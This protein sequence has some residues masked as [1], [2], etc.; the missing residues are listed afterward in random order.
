MQPPKFDPT[1]AN[2]QA[3]L[4]SL[5]ADPRDLLR[6][7]DSWR[8]EDLTP[9][10]KLVMAQLRGRGALGPDGVDNLAKILALAPGTPAVDGVAANGWDPN[11]DGPPPTSGGDGPQAPGGGGL[12]GLDDLSDMAG[13][14][15]LLASIAAAGVAASLQM[16]L[17]AP[18]E[19]SAAFFWRPNNPDMSCHQLE[20]NTYLKGKAANGFFG[21]AV[22]GALN[23]LAPPRGGSGPS[24]PPPTSPAKP[25]QQSAEELQALKDRIHQVDLQNGNWG[26]YDSNLNAKVQKLLDDAAN[27]R[28]VDPRDVA[29]L[30]QIQSGELAAAG[31]QLAANA[32]K[33]GGFEMDADAKE[34][35]AW[36][37]QHSPEAKAA[38]QNDLWNQYHNL[39]DRAG[40]GDL[41]TAANIGSLDDW[42]SKVVKTN[43]ADGSEYID[44]AA[45]DQMK[46]A[47]TASKVDEI[48]TDNTFSQAIA[49]S[50]NNAATAAYG[51]EVGTKLTIVALSAF[52]GG[53]AASML[54]EEG[55]AATLASYG[56]SSGQATVA[57]N[58][59]VQGM[60]AAGQ[61]L[62]YN[63]SL[64]ENLY[65]ATHEG[66]KGFTI[67]LITGGVFHA[68]ASGAA[69]TAEAA[70][71][72]AAGTAAAEG[73]GTQATGAASQS[74]LEKAATGVQQ[75]SKTAAGST[76]VG[77]VIGGTIGAASGGIDAARHGKSVLEGAW[78]GGKQGALEGGVGG[79]FGH[80][81]M[82]SAHVPNTAPPPSIPGAIDDPS[83][84]SPRNTNWQQPVAPPP[85]APA[86]P[87]DLSKPRVGVSDSE[88]NWNTQPAG[89]APLS[90]EPPAAGP[91]SPTGGVA[92]TPRAPSVPPEPPPPETKDYSKPGATGSEAGENW[93][94]QPKSP[95]PPGKA[96]P[97]TVSPSAGETA[98]ASVPDS[99]AAP[100]QTPEPA[101]RDT[102]SAQTL[103]TSAHPERSSTLE[104]L[105]GGPEEPNQ[106]AAEPGQHEPTPPSE[107]E[108]E[109]APARASAPAEEPTAAP[110]PSPAAQ[111]GG[112]HAPTPAS[113]PAAE[114]TAA[115]EPSPAAQGGGEHTPTPAN[116]PAAEPS[117]IAQPG[118][119]HTPTPA[120]A[121]AA[122]P[123]A[124][125]EPSPA[126]QAGGEHAPAPA[127]APAAEP[128]AALDPPPAAQGGGE[129]TPTPASAPAAEPSP[130]A[131]PG[132]EHAPTPAAEP[133]AAPEPSPATQGGGE[134]APTPANAPA[135]E[136]TAAPEPPP[137]TQGGGEHAP[138]TA[139]AP[140]AEP[141]AAPEPSPAT[142]GG[143][144]HA[145]ARAS[146]PAAEPT[147]APEPPP[148]TQGGGEHAPTPTNAPAAEPTAAPEPPPA[149]Q[150]GGEH[151][152]TPANAPAAEPTAAPEP[153][154][155][156]QAGGEHAPTPGN[157]PAAEPTAAPE[158][159]PAAQAGGEHAPTPANA[160]AAEPSPIAQPGSEHAPT[161]AS[162][163]A[164]EP[165]AAP[166][167]SPA[168]PGGGEHAPTQANAPA[169][170]P[171]PIAQPGTEHAPTP[172]S[173]PTA[174]P[175]AA[176]EP[177]PATQ[178]GGEHVPTPANA[179]A[180]EPSPV[181]QPGT[182][183]VPTPASG[184]AAEPADASVPSVPAATPAAPPAPEPYTGKPYTFK[185]APP[186]ATPAVNPAP[187][188]Y[189]GDPYTFTPA[190]PPQK[191]ALPA[192]IDIL[193]GKEH[194]LPPELGGGRPPV[195]QPVPEPDPWGTTIK[196]Q[197][198]DPPPIEEQ[199]WSQ[200][201]GQG[202][203][204]REGPNYNPEDLPWANEPA[205]RGRPDSL[206]G[207]T[208]ADLGEP[209]PPEVLPKPPVV[210]DGP[211]TPPPDEQQPWKQREGLGP[212]DPAAPTYNPE[213]LPWANELPGR[214][215]P[216]SLP[217][218]TISDIGQ[219]V[220]P[221]VLP[222]PPAIENDP[223]QPPDKQPWQ[224]RFQTVD[225]PKNPGRRMTVDNGLPE[226]VDPDGNRYI[227]D[228]EKV[229]PQGPPS[230]YEGPGG[231]PGRKYPGGQANPDG[232]IEPY[233]KAPWETDGPPPGYEGKGG[234]P[235]ERY[236]GGVMNAEGNLDPHPRGAQPA[237]TDHPPETA[238]SSP[239]AREAAIQDLQN[240]PEGEL[241]ERIT[242]AEIVDDNKAEADLYRDALKRKL[243]ETQPPKP[244]I[245]E[246]PAIREAALD[247]LKDLSREDLETRRLVAQM[248]GDNKQ[249][250]LLNEAIKR[251]PEPPSAPDLP[252]LTP[253]EQQEV[254]DA[255]AA[256]SRQELLSLQEATKG[257]P[258]M[259]A[260]IAKA[261]NQAGY[262]PLPAPLD[263]SLAAQPGA[264]HGPT[265]AGAS[266]AEPTAAESSTAPSDLPPERV[267]TSDEQQKMIDGLA[268][269]SRQELLF[270]QEAAKGD[271][272]MQSL[273][274][275][276]MK[277]AGYDPLQPGEV[278][279]S[280]GIH[281]SFGDTTA[282]S[283]SNSAGA[284]NTAPTAP[285][286]P[287]LP[288]KVD[289]A[290]IPPAGEPPSFDDI[291]KLAR[292][293]TRAQLS[294]AAAE[295][296]QRGDL[297][298]ED[299]LTTA[300]AARED[301]Q[302]PL[303]SRTAATRDLPYI[304]PDP[305]P[306]ETPEN[307]KG[308]WSPPDK[309]PGP[310]SSSDGGLDHLDTPDHPGPSGGHTPGPNAPADSEPSGAGL[311]NNALRQPVLD[312]V[313]ER[314]QNI[315]AGP[316][317]QANGEALIDRLQQNNSI[318]Q[319]EADRLRGEW[320]NEVVPTEHVGHDNLKL[321]SREDAGRVGSPYRYV[322]VDTRVQGSGGIQ[323]V[324]NLPGT[325]DSLPKDPHVVRVRVNTKT[326]E[327]TPLSGGIGDERAQGAANRALDHVENTPAQRVDKTANA[328]VYEIPPD[329]PADGHRGGV[330]ADPTDPA[331]A[332]S[333]SGPLEELDTKTA[334]QQLTQA[335]Q[336][337]DKALA[338]NESAQQRGAAPDVQEA[339]KQR[340]DAAKQK[341]DQAQQNYQ[342]ANLDQFNSSRQRLA[343]AQQEYQKA[344]QA[345]KTGTAQSVPADVQNQ[346][347][348]KAAAA[349]QNLDQAQQDYTQA[350]PRR[351]YRSAAEQADHTQAAAQK[352]EQAASDARSA[353]LRASRAADADPGN[354]ALQQQ[355]DAARSAANQARLKSQAAE[356]AMI[357]SRA[358]ARDAANRLTQ[359]LETESQLK[360]DLDK[361]IQDFFNAPGN[362]N[363]GGVRLVADSDELRAQ[364][365][366]LGELDHSLSPDLGLR[367]GTPVGD[368][369]LGVNQ[370]VVNRS[371]VSGDLGAQI[372]ERIHANASPEWQQSLGNNRTLNEGMTHALTL[373]YGE[374]NY[375]SNAA[376]WD[377]KIGGAYPE[378]VQVVRDLQSVVGKDTMRRAFFNGE[379]E[380]MQAKVGNALGATDATQAVAQGRAALAEI[381]NNME[382]LLKGDP[383][384]KLPLDANARSAV[385][386]RL[387]G[388][389]NQL[390][391]GPRLP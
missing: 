9:E 235:G 40:T 292:K 311:D 382:L 114:P 287:V 39:L 325:E 369:T 373:E 60:A 10:Q 389:I 237:F 361:R 8:S 57:F 223:L 22:G 25:Q 185:P 121:P 243:G 362:K 23:S 51:L 222:D 299:I 224:E 387:N 141:T 152:P 42:R 30:E 1:N 355:A 331:G 29:N 315:K 120:S 123:T 31:A 159:P 360:Q 220:P 107:A 47:L 83:V 130:I 297:R 162:A 28:Y 329:T 266:P 357:D 308:I 208:I 45:L 187:E 93:G 348:G 198:I 190:E 322:D 164:A 254:V 241:R 171:S 338:A 179:P 184:P 66:A 207:D 260:F 226:G 218:D 92:E 203:L 349:K 129:H 113:A 259:Q 358:Q 132:T 290:D 15:S 46:Q 251:N 291:Q 295:A 386:A 351:A 148:A 213:D 230:D 55:V 106:G 94:T 72:E 335:Q 99:P 374:G 214:G 126:A 249:V 302:R 169:A 317:A 201:Q 4:Q 150:G 258:K 323:E 238:Y 37:A 246:D 76:L 327:A 256:R 212:A 27:S 12:N 166:E 353:A 340:V 282:P 298:T 84:S 376:T 5:I 154:P 244:E 38:A 217:G 337:Y 277:Q 7:P 149:T 17:A 155:A 281:Q 303:A 275:K 19:E 219:P 43:P 105:E 200:R 81:G 385:Q 271:P 33:A 293:Y 112:E 227:Y 168:A 85:E 108:T 229:N 346:L 265:P 388:L 146:A 375:G 211:L 177:P 135:A 87:V 69:A 314:L 255:L 32:P 384:T 174:A 34:S 253:D 383:V 145:P 144:E 161:P 63:K 289:P 35:L 367:E 156:A 103:N 18:T 285:E 119:E 221:E 381:N 319:A 77:T 257:N 377:P 354:A 261:M 110:E 133:T 209:V 272:E 111:G 90:S 75:L 197:N 98:G 359:H 215:R 122:E 167:P 86:P 172:A 294:E 379:V 6:D 309:S 202:P 336:D 88:A 391:T 343:Q 245:P 333:Q 378:Q 50:Y 181:A 268:G 240:M 127:N 196:G 131:K 316:D 125:P 250:D 296:N 283:S 195:A 160:P 242:Q 231:V 326:G 118:T 262:D 199:P 49:T 170:E 20:V 41:E 321:P 59:A 13:L 344:L 286:P 320:N 109:H 140:A 53:A 342:D 136:P 64:G 134:H 70:A 371:V 279:P 278:P 339:V 305:K 380:A 236:P 142:Q 3:T 288:Q 137:A 21:G 216:D 65:N 234:T 79:F 97:E 284:G 100:P 189:T 210:E 205:G 301:M 56:F 153:L 26:N 11:S 225:D 178:G 363:S 24:A 96:A 78:E 158:P 341:L 191:P 280:T 74:L 269:K 186:P 300:H 147:A 248:E 80:A 372:H 364:Q 334:R 263:P 368:G 165:T 192:D 390:K 232:V 328:P 332:H 193:P 95:P 310:G 48:R 247:Q 228:P 264:E 2:F 180:A 44:A 182:E 73:A 36:V 233:Q 68:A 239:A 128:T 16:A 307:L 173:E 276:A 330:A 366:A 163:P 151:T 324:A 71:A 176:P 82:E 188:P 61:A 306:P 14:W 304:P 67:G 104:A 139:S 206:P 157:A 91:K 52:A 273:V 347:D 270:L 183:H 350:D 370:P 252:P 115:P 102:G 312:N 204:Q 267:L 117:P 318:S 54:A 143:G 101:A 313:R 62:D 124:A 194:L 58:A 356:Q 274:A 175:T 345:Q 89:R 138:T 365:K 116:A 352:A